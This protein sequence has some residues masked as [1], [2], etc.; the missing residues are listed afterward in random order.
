MRVNVCMCMS[1][2]VCLSMIFSVLRENFVFLL[3]NLQPRKSDVSKFIFVCLVLK[4]KT[5]PMPRFELGIPG[6]L[7]LTSV[8]LTQ[9]RR[10]MR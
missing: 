7:Q 10:P 6:S 1:M 5:S 9:F 4:K 3:K 8:V 2:C